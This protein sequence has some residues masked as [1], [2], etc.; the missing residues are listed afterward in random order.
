MAPSDIII[1][2]CRAWNRIP[3][4]SKNAGRVVCHSCGQQIISVVG[5]SSGRVARGEK[6]TSPDRRRSAGGAGLFLGLIAT[7]VFGGLSALVSSEYS[8]RGPI[9]SAQHPVTPITPAVPA[10]PIPHYA[11]PPVATPPLMPT[12]SAAPPAVIDKQPA[13]PAAPARLVL[14]Y[15]APGCPE[16]APTYESAKA[17]CAGKDE[18]PCKGERYCSLLQNGVC[19]PKIGTYVIPRPMLHNLSGLPN[20]EYMEA[21]TPEI[22][23]LISRGAKY[24]S[25]GDYRSAI[26]EYSKALGQY[27]DS[28]EAL[29]DRARVYEKSDQKNRSLA[30]YCKLLLVDANSARYK[31]A[32]DRIA[33]LTGTAPPPTGGNDRVATPAPDKA[34]PTPQTGSLERGGPRGRIAPFSVEGAAGTNYY[35]KLVNVADAKDQILIFVRGGETYSTKMPLG[36][37]RLR[38]A[39]GDTWYGKDDLFGPGTQFFQLRS[40]MGAGTGDSSLLHFYQEGRQIMGTTLSFKPVVYGNLEQ[41]T[42]SREEFLK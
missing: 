11:P 12:S 6:I 19:G 8:P 27:P 9:A 35:I 37:Y 14:S 31:I 36:T 16:T 32:L 25:A 1:C 38:A 10:V 40:K 2:K 15:P 18:K 13:A 7:L 33:V 5:D 30:D 34:L 17:Y 20:I 29:V 24:E 28:A 21:T 26:R 22:N 3:A 39:S 41:E 42:I 4:G 23:D